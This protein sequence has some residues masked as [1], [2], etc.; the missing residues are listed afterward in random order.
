MKLH[1]DRQ[2][3]DI[4]LTNPNFK[5]PQLLRFLKRDFGKIY[6]ADADIWEKYT[7]GRHTI[8]AMN[9]FEKYFSVTTFPMEFS[10]ETFRFFLA[11]HDIGKPEAIRQGDKNQQ[12]FYTK[13]IMSTVFAQLN[14]SVIEIKI[15][16]ALVIT[17]CLGKYIQGDILEQ[18]TAETIAGLAQE[19][20]VKIID[21]FELLTIFFRCDAG[22]YTEDAGGLKSLDHLF[23]FNRKIPALLFSKKSD[24]KINDLHQH[25]AHIG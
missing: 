10:R 5:P 24:K 19:A 13:R 23:I 21:F 16:N 17:D 9:Q 11:L 12:H 22:S 15:A 8:M 2:A 3:L 25:L 7:I 18:D 20:G 4:V 6:L 1:F 14:F